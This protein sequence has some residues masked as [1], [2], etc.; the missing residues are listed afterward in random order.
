[1]DFTDNQD[2]DS[3]SIEMIRQH[4]ISVDKSRSKSAAVSSPPDFSSS[5]SV[6][7]DKSPLESSRNRSRKSLKFESPT[8]RELAKLVESLVAADVGWFLFKLD[9]FNNFIATTFLV[10]RRRNHHIRMMK[11]S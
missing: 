3:D 9:L 7:S 11:S 2:S 4:L 5:P 6:D 1:M 8:S 10:F